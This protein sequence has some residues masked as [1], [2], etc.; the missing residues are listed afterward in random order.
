MHPFTFLICEMR[1]FSLFCNGFKGK[2]YHKLALISTTAGTD[3]VASD[4]KL[5]QDI[6][7][8]HF[9][10]INNHN[11]IKKDKELIRISP[12]YPSHQISLRK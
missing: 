3:N 11:S 12:S 2:Y 9:Y 1:V 8:Q 7:K 10:I 6:T 5:K 4:L